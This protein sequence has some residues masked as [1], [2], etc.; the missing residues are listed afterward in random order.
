MLADRGRR[1][2]GAHDR[3]LEFT[4]STAHHLGR[5][6][7]GGGGEALHVVRD[8]R[9]LHSSSLFLSREGDFECLT[10]NFL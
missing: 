3:G 6:D 7:D 9:F 2:G 8:V 5:A 1:V 10:L 4:G